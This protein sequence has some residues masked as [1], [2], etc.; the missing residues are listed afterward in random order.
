MNHHHRIN[1]FKKLFLFCFC[2]GIVPVITLG[3]FSYAK[4]S[5]LLLDKANR[6]SAESV[7]Q[8][9]LR[10]EQKMKMVDNT[11]TQF[12]GASAVISAM[13]QRLDSSNYWL[14]E[15]LI[16]SIHRLQTYEFGLA[17]VYLVNLYQDWILDSRGQSSFEQ[18]Y[19]AKSIDAYVG[20]PKAS[21][22][23]SMKLPWY[24]DGNPL[25]WNM[26]LVKKIPNNSIK[27]M[28]LL[29]AI[30]PCIELNKMLPQGGEPG[31][32]YVLDDKL[33]VIAS[34][35][36]EQVGIDL[37]KE[38]V[39]GQIQGEQL[40]ANQF[41]TDI[42]NDAYGIT[43]R[44]SSY[45]G[46]TYVNK[47]HIRDIKQESRAIGWLTIAI[48]LSLLLFLLLLSFQG[49][50]QL[51]RPIRRLYDI[52]LKDPDTPKLSPRKDEL[53]WIESKLH[54]LLSN[55]AQMSHQLK[56]FFV[57]KLLQGAVGANEI[58]ER[59]DSLGLSSWKSIRVLCVRIDTMES[60]NYKESD[61]DLLLFAIH[62]ITS[63]LIAAELRLPPV[64]INE[65]QVTVIG[66]HAELAEESKAEAYGQGKAIQTAIQD[67][68]KLSVSIGISSAITHPADMP[69]AFLEAKE[70][71][72][73]GVR[74]GYESILFLED[75]HSP[76]MTVPVTFP[77]HI[78][79]ELTEQIRLLD[80]GRANLLIEE[81]MVVVAN[82]SISHQEFQ[83]Y[84]M[85]LLVELLRLYQ[86]NGGQMQDLVLNEKAVVSEMFLLKSNK[87]IVVW[88]QTSVIRP[89]IAHIEQRRDS[90]YTSISDQILTIIHSEF[91]TPLTLEL[92]GV[93]LS[94]H[95]EYV[96]RVFR[97]ETGFAFGEYLSGYRLQI[98]KKWLVETDMTVTEISER[99]MYNKPQNFIR[100]FRKMEQVTPGQYRELFHSKSKRAAEQQGTSNAEASATKKE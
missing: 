66:S 73:Y 34:A 52:I 91:D 43:Y 41:Q 30:L 32:F 96:G 22:W 51:Y 45:N 62:N 75:M 9:R 55:Q 18:H 7:E 19:L 11:Q 47:I 93:R 8:T 65:F 31:E 16:Q 37:S 79:S 38:P 68:L 20:I 48:C 84:L 88:F 12:I 50:R 60:T 97:K 36:P 58:M 24:E 82:K 33:R 85:R 27:P 13:E 6:S 21:F 56:E 3:Y 25:Q 69:G 23:A 98:A 94:Y 42:G 53:S 49:S 87:E 4:S 77:Q 57:H 83:L 64:V 95:P 15:D 54:M 78:V 70:A 10:F 89:L 76:L 39:I 40:E 86:D 5:A 46:W 63:E 2:I 35:H 14:Y 80:E 61:R 28:G 26:A 17:E 74:L 44:K 59:S 1:F 29:V 99:L 100:Y 72:A 92:C 90:L 81:F 71:L 67:Y